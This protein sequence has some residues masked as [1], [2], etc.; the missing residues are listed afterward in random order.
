MEHTTFN[1]EDHVRSEWVDYNG[2]MNDAAYAQAFSLAVDAFM[3]YIALD[4][5]GRNKHA[6]TIFTLETHLCYL[7]EA[8]EGEKIYVTSQLLDV[9]EK[10]LHIFF[11]MKNSGDDVVSTSEQMLMGIDTT[12]GKAA[13]FPK[14][15][16]AIIEKLW[17][18]DKQLETPKQ[19]GR[20]IAIRR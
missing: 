14:A 5:K 13:P 9:D 2:H 15:V 11:V 18:A 7:R 4:E 12:H 19:V 17:K 6:Y 1:Y 8:N 20:K 10:R 3:D 16:A